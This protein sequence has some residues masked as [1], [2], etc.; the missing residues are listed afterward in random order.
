MSRRA[1]FQVSAFM[2]RVLARYNRL[3]LWMSVVNEYCPRDRS[4]PF[5]ERCAD[6]I[7][8]LH[9]SSKYLTTSLAVACLLVIYGGSVRSSEAER[10]NI[11]FII[12]DDQSP[13]DLKVYNSRSNAPNAPYRSVGVP[14]DGIGCGLSNGILDGRCLYGFATYDHVGAYALAHP[15]QA[16]TNQ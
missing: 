5:L 15:Q 4:S 8:M 14:G 12:V 3:L 6:E 13:F 2:T 9:R 7:T 16:K 11:L 10:P 1:L